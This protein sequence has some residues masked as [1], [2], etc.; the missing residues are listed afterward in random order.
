MSRRSRSRGERWF[1]ATGPAA[2]SP[3]ATWSQPRTPHAPQASRSRSSNSPTGS[4]DGG[5]RAPAHHLDAAWIGVV[6]HLAGTELHGLPLVT[7]GRSSG[8]RVACRTAA[9]V[10]AIGVVCLAFPLVP[11]ARTGKEPAPSRL[12]ELDAVPVPLLVVQG[13]SDRFGM[14][15]ATARR[16]V[17]QIRGDHSL[18]SDLRRTRHGRRRVAGG[19]HP[20]TSIGSVSW[21][22]RMSER[23]DEWLG[24]LD[25]A[26]LELE[27]LDGDF[28]G[29]PVDD[30]SCEY[31]FVARRP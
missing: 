15:P 20:V 11:P 29:S 25:V 13:A 8:A 16:T 30:E 22:E 31:V 4:P 26:G 28:A 18:R 21:D 23:Y 3:L 17:V 7:G 6:E 1:S 10:G 9:T 2:A 27:T 19:S 12:P 14:P 24:P 5:A